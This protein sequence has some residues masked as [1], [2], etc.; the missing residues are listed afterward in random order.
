MDT[1]WNQAT[2]NRPD[3][4]RILDAPFVKANIPE[5]VRQL[6]TEPAWKKNERNG[7]TVFKSDNLAVVVVALQK[8]VMIEDNDVEGYITIQV[9]NGR[10][11]VKMGNTEQELA[12]GELVVIH[13]HITHS[14]R[15][16]EESVLVLS[17]SQQ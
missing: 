4:D 17:N 3:G 11:T 1:K 8:N 12:S 7:I 2:P 14:I 9:L 15:A 13:P 6:K 5:L 10:I 16:E